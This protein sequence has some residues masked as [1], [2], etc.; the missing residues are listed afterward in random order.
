MS[1][2]RDLKTVNCG[3]II[4][5]PHKDPLTNE[6]LYLEV[7]RPEKHNPN[8]QIVCYYLWKN[9]YKKSL[10]K[11]VEITLY[12][13]KDGTWGSEVYYFR[14]KMDIHHYY[15]RNYENFIGM[16]KDYYDIVKWIHPFF[17]Q[18]FGN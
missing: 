5:I 9:S 17:L 18:I 2:I 12:R 6:T 10:P 15:S 11:K 16:P 4:S 14:T 13:R 1:M 3:E 8:C 7:L